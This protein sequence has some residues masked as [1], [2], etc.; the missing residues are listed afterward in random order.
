MQKKIKYLFGFL[1]IAGVLVYLLFTTFS[2][3]LQY[4][5]TASELL[6]AQNNYRGKILKVA[7]MAKGVVRAEEGGA[8][9]YHFT[10]VEEGALLSVIYKGI[11]PDTFK[12]N[13]QVV[14]TGTLNP[15]GTF[16][17]T[18]ILAK[19]ASKYQAKVKE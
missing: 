17:A 11:V 18:E 12:D 1:L 5:V 15:D 2:S 7:G 4:Y 19:C 10:V 9:V 16:I 8:S 13:A 3:S 6:K 14:V